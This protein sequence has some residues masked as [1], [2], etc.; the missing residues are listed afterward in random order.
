M[1]LFFAVTAIT[2]SACVARISA[3]FFLGYEIGVRKL[4]ANLLMGL[5]ILQL[6]LNLVLCLLEPLQCL[7]SDFGSAQ[8]S[9]YEAINLG[10]ELCSSNYFW[11]IFF[12][13]KGGKLGGYLSSV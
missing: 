1:L 5:A 13:T 6:V 11:R 9:R 7:P 8:F 4:S 10:D 3:I 12:E 2:S